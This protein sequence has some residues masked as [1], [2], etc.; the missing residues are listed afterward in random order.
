MVKKN[1]KLIVLSALVL[2]LLSLLICSHPSEEPLVVPSA[3][4]FPVI[5]TAM[6]HSEDDYADI[7]PLSSEN[8]NYENGYD[9]D[10]SPIKEVPVF[11]VDATAVPYVDKDLSGYTNENLKGWFYFNGPISI[12]GL[13]ISGPLLQSSNN[14]YY[15]THDEYNKYSYNGSIYADY[16]NDLSSIRKNKNIVIYAHAR[17]SFG[18]LKYLDNAK[19]WWADANNHFIKIT[20][21]TEVT[22]WQVFSWYETTASYDYRKVKF[23]SGKNGIAKYAEKLQSNNEISALKAFTFTDDDIILTLSTCKGS[24]KNVRVAV[25]AILIKCEQR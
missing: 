14:E 12:A 8:A 11:D 25:H 17:G 9:S 21:K 19:R 3:E 20:T 15:L 24:N 13:P 7:A 4:E 16:R 10:A 5:F 6:Y 18:G 22:V 2:C 23:T 1:I